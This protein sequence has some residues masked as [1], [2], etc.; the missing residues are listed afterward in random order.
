V[1]VGL[2]VS[3]LLKQ[4]AVHG[5]TVATVSM[6]SVCLCCANLKLCSSSCCFGALMLQL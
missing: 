1:R 5:T 4:A 3:L 2:D 6:G